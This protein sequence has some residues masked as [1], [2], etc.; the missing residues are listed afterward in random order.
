MI[1]VD[2]HPMLRSLRP[3]WA[4]VTNADAMLRASRYVFG[5]S[6]AD[7]EFTGISLSEEQRRVEPRVA[8]M[9]IPPEWRYLMPDALDAPG[10]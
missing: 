8:V 3:S 9:N 2:G 5:R 4:T 7:L 1:D 10:D 6:E